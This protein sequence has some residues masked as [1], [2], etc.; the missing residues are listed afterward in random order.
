MTLQPVSVASDIINAGL[1]KAMPLQR[2]GY[3]TGSHLLAYSISE[4]A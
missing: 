3:E 2:T 4:A 1:N